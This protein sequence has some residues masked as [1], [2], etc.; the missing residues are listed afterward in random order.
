[1]DA[2]LDVG[3]MV[4]SIWLYIGFATQ[5]SFSAIFLGNFWNY[6]SLYICVS[7]VLC[8][9][10]SLESA[11]W[12]ALFQVGTLE[13]DAV[14]ADICRYFGSFCWCDAGTASF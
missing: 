6:I 4:T 7:H 8:V 10:R 9:C 1:M 12:G 13:E 3:Y 11:D 14:L 5:E 2:F